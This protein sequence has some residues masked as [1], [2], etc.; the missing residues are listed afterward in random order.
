MRRELAIKVDYL[1]QLYQENIQQQSSQRLIAPW[2]LDENESKEYATMLFP[3]GRGSDDYGGNVY[4][5]AR[6]GFGQYLRRRTTFEDFGEKLR[7]DDTT[8]IIEQMLEGLRQAGLVEQVVEP[9]NADDKGGYQLPASAMVWV[10]GDGSQA[11]HDPIRVPRES[12][13]GQHTNA[14]FVDFYRATAA[15]LHDI[16]ARE[17]TAQVPYDLRVQREEDFRHGKLPILYCSPTMELGIDISELNVVNMRNVP[18]TPANYAQR[19]GRAGRSGQPALVFSY[20]STG[21]SHDQYFFKRPEQMVAG[22]VTPPRLDLANEDLVRA[23]VYAIWLAETGLS[24]G[25]SLKDVLE[26]GGDDPTLAL[27]GSVRE[28]VEDPG[29][30]RRARVRAADVLDTLRDEL[31]AS[32]W[33]TDDWLDKALA[34]VASN[35]DRTC[36]R[37]RGL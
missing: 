24:L 17:H 31:R 5:S 28:S 20:C 3:R 27:L 8:T 33:Y 30:R 36:E 21:S 25:E 18:P 6:G 12:S 13:E 26:I 9:H 7:L 2:A 10:T 16:E 34:Q 11:F 15:N 1:D 4:L 35:F 32:D 19:S 14:F 23:H 29:A 22:A 37:W